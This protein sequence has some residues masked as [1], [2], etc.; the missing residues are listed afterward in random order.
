MFFILYSARA[1]LEKSLEEIKVIS[2]TD[3]S[4]D[5]SDSQ[6]PELKT[7]EEFKLPHQQQVHREDP[8]TSGAPLVDYTGGAPLGE[9]GELMM[10]QWT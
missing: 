3:Y 6:V 1:P 7:P 9:G 8:A 2:V 5:E 4:S 10:T